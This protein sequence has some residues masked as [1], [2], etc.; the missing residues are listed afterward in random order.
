MGGQISWQWGWSFV[1]RTRLSL[2]KKKKKICW[3]PLHWNAF[4]CMGNSFHSLSATPLLMLKNVTYVKCQNK[5]PHTFF[6]MITPC[7]SSA[8][9]SHSF[10]VTVLNLTLFSSLLL[11]SLPSH[12]SSYS[13]PHLPAFSFP[14]HSLIGLSPAHHSPSPPPSQNCLLLLLLL[15]FAVKTH[16]LPQQRSC[17]VHAVWV[18][19]RHSDSTCPDSSSEIY[20][21]YLFFCG[22][23]FKTVDLL[24]LFLISS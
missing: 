1:Y 5:W 14:A 3:T 21:S 23:V 6:L 17:S 8:L 18:L 13:L 16:K 19:E 10:C 15:D 20:L 11:L 7:F 4:A 9:F 24:W 22:C 2:K 12:P